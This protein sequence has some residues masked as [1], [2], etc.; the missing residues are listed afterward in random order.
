MTRTDVAIKMRLF[1]D[2]Y[3][4]ILSA[5]PDG[6]GKIDS[7]QLKVKTVPLMAFLWGGMVLM[8]I[9][10]GIVIFFGY[11]SDTQGTNTGSQMSDTTNVAKGKPKDG[12]KTDDKTRSKSSPKEDDE[13]YRKM[14]ED[15]LKNL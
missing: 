14:L 3:I 8:S 6:N 9:G 2:V 10:I 5:D 1:E 15:E 7:V 4:N 11:D 12:K 13:K